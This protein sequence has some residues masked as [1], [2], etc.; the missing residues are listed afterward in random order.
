MVELTVVKAMAALQTVQFSRKMRFYDVIMKRDAMQIVNAVRATNFEHIVV[1]IQERTCLLKSCRI[2]HV[3][4]DANSTTYS[5]A[6]EVTKYVMDMVWIKK[7]S[8][9]I[10]DIVIREQTA[11]V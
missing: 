6:Q 3:K 10:Y 7:I 5:L 11:L 1:G 8:N 4:M 9:C 2:E